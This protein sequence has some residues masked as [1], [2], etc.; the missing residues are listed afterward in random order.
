MVLWCFHD[1]TDSERYTWRWCFC[2]DSFWWSHPLVRFVHEIVQNDQ[3]CISGVEGVQVRQSLLKV[4]PIYGSVQSLVF[5]ITPQDAIQDLGHHMSDIV[6]EF[7]EKDGF[8]TSGWS[9][10]HTGKQMD[11][12][13]EI[14][15]KSS[16]G[17]FKHECVAR[18]VNKV[19]SSVSI[20]CCNYDNSGP[21]G[22]GV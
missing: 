5:S 2:G 22:G 17:Y 15:R 14:T 12:W 4:H 6:Y 21:R 20:W 10:D 3:V 8:S 1:E 7:P 18:Q 9:R 11:P 19:R 16:A 13:H